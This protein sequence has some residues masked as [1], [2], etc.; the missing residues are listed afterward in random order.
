MFQR[1]FFDLTNGPSSIRDEAGIWAADLDTAVKE[2]RIVIEEMR[3]NEEL[4]E[5][6][7]G[8]LLVI[9]DAEGEAV[10]TL[11]VVPRDPA[12]TSGS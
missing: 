12:P 3:D 8:W 7:E 10:M 5:A 11:P 2:A 6:E 1:F 4:T 9:R